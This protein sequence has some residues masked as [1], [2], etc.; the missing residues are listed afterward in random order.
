VGLLLTTKNLSVGNVSLKLE[1][2]GDAA[3]G[4]AK[5][6]D[7]TESTEDKQDQRAMLLNAE[8]QLFQNLKIMV[9]VW[10]DAG[11]LDP[12]YADLTFSDEF[13]ASIQFSD[14]KPQISEKEV[15]ETEKLKMD[16][17]FSTLELSLAKIYPEKTQQEILD[18][19]DQIIEEQALL[20]QSIP[21][22]DQNQENQE[23]VNGVSEGSNQ[24]EPATTSKN[25]VQ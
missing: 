4:V 18:L 23:V 17:K 2:G 16:N 7:A 10:K 25:S 12:A 9:P 15:V 3:S 20:N 13:L 6:L 11:A 24:G 8:K 19:R 14:P 1:G 21:Q 5:I 22:E